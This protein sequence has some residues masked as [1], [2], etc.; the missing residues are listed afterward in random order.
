MTGEL[1]G[2]A[3]RTAAA[4]G[5]ALAGDDP[6]LRIAARMCANDAR[7]RMAAALLTS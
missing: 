7:E 4:M 2:D 1:P 5:E 6:F 3:A